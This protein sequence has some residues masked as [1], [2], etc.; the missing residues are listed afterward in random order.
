M[1][2]ELALRWLHIISAVALVGG[3]FFMRFAGLPGLN[4]ITDADQRESA[5]AR[6]RTAWSKIVMGTSGLLLISG[7]VNVM[8]II[9]TYGSN[10]DG[11]Y[12]ALVGIKLLL[13]LS[14][15]ALSAILSGRS[16]LAQQLRQ[17]ESLWLTVNLLLAIGVICLAGYMKQIDRTPKAPETSAQ[18]SSV[19][20]LAKNE[21]IADV[22]TPFWE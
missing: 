18:A 19:Y 20:A 15:F 10:F 4:A 12:H 7:L 1:L 6:M 22:E 16:T 17:K 8:R 9:G 5:A 13:A 21:S 3:C 14:V 11:P 2:L